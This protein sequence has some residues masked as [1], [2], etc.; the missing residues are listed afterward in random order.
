MMGRS[1]DCF[2]ALIE[3]TQVVRISCHLDIICYFVLTGVLD[4]TKFSLSFTAKP[5]IALLFFR[6]VHDVID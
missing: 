3:G 5:S 6:T 4:C 1:E 2:D